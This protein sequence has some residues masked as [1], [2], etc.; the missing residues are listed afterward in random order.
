MCCKFFCYF[1]PGAGPSFCAIFPISLALIR[2]FSVLNWN[3]TLENK[4][5]TRSKNQHHV[6]ILYSAT[7]LRPFCRTG[8]KQPQTEIIKNYWDIN[9]VWITRTIAILMLFELQERS[10]IMSMFVRPHI[11]EGRK[12]DKFE[13]FTTNTSRWG[14]NA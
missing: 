1:E 10:P 7:E 4:R 6:L 5:V 14:F 2:K 12:F 13:L 11:L 8:D 3:F 9:A